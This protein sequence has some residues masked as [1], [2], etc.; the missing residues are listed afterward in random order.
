MTNVVDIIAYQT[1]EILCQI[2]IVIF[3]AIH[4]TLMLEMKR[5]TLI[6]FHSRAYPVGGKQQFNKNTETGILVSLFDS[7]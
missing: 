6:R 3:I 1:K 5:D 4:E 2:Q 7:F